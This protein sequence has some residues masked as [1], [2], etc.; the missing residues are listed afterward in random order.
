MGRGLDVGW[1]VGRG[2]VVGWRLGCLGGVGRDGVDARIRRCGRLGLRR[3]CMQ[4]G[5]VTIDLEMRINGWLASQ[6]FLVN[7]GFANTDLENC[8]HE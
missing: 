1:R 8:K 5:R 3:D 7:C 2:L 6:Q 4:V